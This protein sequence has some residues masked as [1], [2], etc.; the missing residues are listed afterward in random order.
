MLA[1]RIFDI[2]ISSFLLIVLFPF[3]LLVSFFVS[4]DGGPV[5]FAQKRVGC[6]AS[7][8]IFINFGP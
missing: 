4:L 6:A 8:L 2:F 3:L 1:K 5:F 7:F